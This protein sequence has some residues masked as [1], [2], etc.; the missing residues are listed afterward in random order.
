MNNGYYDVKKAAEAEHKAIWGAWA[1]GGFLWLLLGVWTD[2]VPILGALVYWLLWV[3]GV[4]AT[5]AAIYASYQV[6]ER[7]AKARRDAL[8][9]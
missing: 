9:R 7:E 4:I 5:C 8:G 2:G 3:F 1:V 6:S